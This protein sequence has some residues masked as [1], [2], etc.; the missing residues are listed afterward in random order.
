MLELSVQDARALASSSVRTL[1]LCD[2]L[3]PQH[4]VG[5]LPALVCPWSP[6]DRYSQ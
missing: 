2:V 4:T 1:G 5:L 6:E 3:H